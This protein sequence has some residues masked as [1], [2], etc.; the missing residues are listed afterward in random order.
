MTR[1][2]DMLTKAYSMVTEAAASGQE[3]VFLPI[4][5]VQELVEWT[6]L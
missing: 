3:K 1:K 4:L 2:E 6:L 5:A